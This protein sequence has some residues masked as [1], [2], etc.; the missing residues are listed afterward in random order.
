M[1]QEGMEGEM[2]RR[3]GRK[4]GENRWLKV[5]DGELKGQRREEDEEDR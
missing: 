5:K 1:M 3:E 2:E 4:E